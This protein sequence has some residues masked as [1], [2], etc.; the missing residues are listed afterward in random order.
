MTLWLTL[1][2]SVDITCAAGTPIHVSHFTSNS[3]IHRTVKQ[4]GAH[5]ENLHKI[6]KSVHDNNHKVIPF[7]IYLAMLGSDSHLL[8]NKLL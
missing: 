2:I 6:L 3:V 4:T 5:Y 7:P 8:A 1:M